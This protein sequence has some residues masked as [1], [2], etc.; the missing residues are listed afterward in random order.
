MTTL[1]D[2]DDITPFDGILNISQCC[3]ISVTTKGSGFPTEKIPRD[4]RFCFNVCSF[5]YY[6]LLLLLTEHSVG[7]NQCWDPDPQDLHVFGPPG[8]GSISQGSEFGSGSFFY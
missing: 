4:V 5:K 7:I 6:Y 3:L 8:S 1:S 2:C